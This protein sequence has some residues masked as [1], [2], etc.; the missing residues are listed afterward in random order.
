MRHAGHAADAGERG[1]GETVARVKDNTIGALNALLI[2][3]RVGCR[4]G[5]PLVRLQSGGSGPSLAGWDGEFARVPEAGADIASG[6][7][8]HLIA[9]MARVHLMSDAE[10]GLDALP[11]ERNVAKPRS[12]GRGMPGSCA[13]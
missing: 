6:A 10:L 9:P 8:G 7:A 13:A 2:G 1:G 4:G 3:C 5:C 11:D 12:R